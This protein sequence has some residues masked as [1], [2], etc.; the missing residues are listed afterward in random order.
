MCP[1]V[2]NGNQSTRSSEGPTGRPGTHQRSRS[3]IDV[4]EVARVKDELAP[5]G[6]AI[7]PQSTEMQTESDLGYQARQIRNYIEAK[8]QIDSQ[9][10]GHT[11]VD[12][13]KS[14]RK[15]CAIS[16]LDA[17]KLLPDSNCTSWISGQAS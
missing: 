11:N 13:Q 4:R 5:A 8:K 3:S 6:Q 1:N 16:N 17:M 15:S 9:A 10:L 12:T 7:Y 14:Y 2:T